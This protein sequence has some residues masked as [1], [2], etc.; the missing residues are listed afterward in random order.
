MLPQRGS[1]AVNPAG[2]ATMSLYP[3][4]QRGSDRIVDRVLDIGAV[5]VKESD[6]ASQD[7]ATRRAAQRAALSKK[8]MWSVRSRGMK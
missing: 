8:L 1:L 3:T 4:D 7:L 6:Y 5:E 2:G